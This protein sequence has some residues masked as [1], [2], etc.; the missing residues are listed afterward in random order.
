MVHQR[1]WHFKVT[2]SPAVPKLQAPAP[3]DLKAHRYL[4]ADN[5]SEGGNG[6]FFSDRQIQ[7]KA[8]PA[9]RSVDERCGKWEK[10]GTMKVITTTSL[11]KLETKEK[12][13][14]ERD[15][16]RLHPRLIKI[17]EEL[18][19]PLGHEERKSLRMEAL[20]I[21]LKGLAVPIPEGS[22]EKDWHYQFW[23][24]FLDNFVVNIV[25]KG[26]MYKIEKVILDNEF[27]YMEWER[28]IIADSDH[29]FVRAKD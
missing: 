10:G 25:P 26:T 20:D 7:R 22:E 15:N 5:S 6:P 9:V 19:E 3:A 29:G 12:A 28:L 23:N 21:L 11:Q 17:L 24:S 13:C 1:N 2:K 18:K 4:W 8:H 14:W 27:E 16:L